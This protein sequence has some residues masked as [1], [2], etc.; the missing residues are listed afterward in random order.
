M[1]RFRQIFK[2]QTDKNRK[3]HL[4][5]NEDK[6]YMGEF[7][8]NDV[9]FDMVGHKGFVKGYVNDYGKLVVE[10][11]LKRREFPLW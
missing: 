2:V 9:L 7:P 6:S 11:K 3:T 8:F 1:F 4:V 10:R 5:Y